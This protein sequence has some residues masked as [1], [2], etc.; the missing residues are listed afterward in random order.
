MAFVTDS[1][2][3]G[4]SG[5][6]VVDLASGRSWRKLS[7]HP[8]TSPEPSFGA[9]LEG[10]PLLLRR[11]GESPRP[12]LLGSD[13]IALS[14]NATR[15][16]F[17]PLSGRTLWSASVDA[18]ADQALP[19]LIVAKTLEREERRFA[20]DGLEADAQGRLYLTD[21]EHNAVVVRSQ[22]GEYRTLV[23]DPRMW[24]P[25]TLA[26]AP[27]GW[28]WFTANQLHRLPKF[29]AGKDLRR[30]PMLLLRVKTDGAPVWTG[31]LPAASA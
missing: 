12:M 1:A 10:Q 21:W 31:G 29:H 8:S 4:P 2:V 18:L 22:A 6:I 19:D 14:A 17:S 5:I 16:F 27:D 7:G 9:K 11:P 30:R 26:L 13:G 23:S 24:W 28:L 3:E 15:L 20:S 25:D